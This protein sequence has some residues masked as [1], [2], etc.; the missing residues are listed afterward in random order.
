MID[1]KSGKLFFSVEEA[2]DLA[3]VP[4]EEILEHIESGRLPATRPIGQ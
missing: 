2:A 1:P 3:G 4:V